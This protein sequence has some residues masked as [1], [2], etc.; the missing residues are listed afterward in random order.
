M[1]GNGI[2]FF[3]D[4]RVYRG[5]WLQNKMH[6]YGEFLWPDGRKYIGYYI[7]DK[8]EGFGI[9]YWNKPNKTY[10]GF[11]KNG[12]QEGLGCLVNQTSL[13]YGT[14]RDGINIKYFNRPST[15]LKTLIASELKYIKCFKYELQDALEFI[16]LHD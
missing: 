6:G 10:I 5:E 16:K 8:K 9:F 12:K 11:W 4:E 14:W 13:L 1:H 7:E 3:I 2:I 15:A